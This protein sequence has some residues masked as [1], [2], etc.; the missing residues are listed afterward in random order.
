[1]PNIKNPFRND[2]MRKQFDLMVSAH[3]T[4][5]RDLFLPNGDQRRGS[6]IANAFWDGHKNE[7][8]SLFCRDASIR[9][10]PAYACWKAGRS[11]ALRDA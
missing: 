6:S 3:D 1:M 9:N 2:V 8:R 11:V 4:K 5:H 10:T 7:T